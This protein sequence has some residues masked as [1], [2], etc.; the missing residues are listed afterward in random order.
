MSRESGGA[1]SYA[2]RSEV[3]RDQV[4]AS[5]QFFWIVGDDAARGNDVG[6]TI[7]GI[8]IPSGP[9]ST[10]REPGARSARRRR[11]VTMASSGLPV[12]Q[13]A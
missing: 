8:R 1:F 6:Y 5:L 3:L 4:C 12:A 10:Q 2:G 11:T 13:Q 7:A 9:V